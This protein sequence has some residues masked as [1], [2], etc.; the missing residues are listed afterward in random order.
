MA[1]IQKR[2][3]SYRIRVSDGFDPETGARRYRTK[4]WTP[5]PDMTAKQI[6]KELERQ[7]V[8]FEEHCR[9]C[10]VSD[11]SIRLRAFVERW[12]TEYAA[13]QLKRTT[14][15]Y[16]DDLLRRILPA[17]GH[18]KLS[19]ITPAHINE[20]Y[21]N[22]RERGIRTDIKYAPKIDF[23]SFL[24]ENNISRQ[25]LVD[26]AGISMTTLE[27]L[28]SGNNV[29]PRTAEKLCSA[30]ET[31]IC[32]LF[33]ATG[34]ERSFSPKT[35]LHY[36]RC[37]S[38]IFSKAVKWGCMFSNPCDRVDPPK[39]NRREAQFLDEEQTT[40]LLESLSDA[41]LQY[42]VMINLMVFTGARRG[43]VC[44]LNWTDIDWET[45]MIH[46]QRNSLYLPSVGM[47]ED[48]TK[49]ES[50]DHI[51]NVPE[52]ILDMLRELQ[53][54]Q[55]G[56]K[57]AM[58]DAWQ[59]NGKVFT[60]WNGRPIHPSSVSTWLRKHCERKGLA[61]ATPHMLRHTSATLLLMQGIPLK[62]VSKRLGHS[63]A[64]T[65]SDIYGHSLQSLDEI[66]ADRLDNILT[67]AK[68]FTDNKE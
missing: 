49:T 38:S 23:K 64:S 24:S 48:T 30:L 43:E 39:L 54:E 53:K 28:I 5:S 62:S 51:I 15:A 19:E 42:R 59:E 50:S 40:A 4:T 67:P 60:Q 13:R 61:H 47:Y 33:E 2:G 10:T 12:R 1:N 27:S 41:P 35:L 16:Y 18:L 66:A 25:K 29:S 63:Q 65:T 21:A 36:H 44:G 7:A 3:G 20:F 37:L 8:L 45:N 11:D 55:N 56:Q 32:E 9:K 22:L 68:A 46:I 17:L 31:D 14:I 52:R 57:S 58:G 26:C 6:E 34:G